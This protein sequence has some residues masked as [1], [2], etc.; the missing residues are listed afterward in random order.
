MKSNVPYHIVHLSDLHLTPSDGKARSEPNILGPLKG[1]NE[2]FRQLLTQKSITNANLI[3]VTGDITDRGDVQSWK[4]FWNVIRD[5]G[6]WKKTL[7]VPGNHD[8]C[9]LGVRTG[10]KK[11]LAKRDLKR[12]V[13]GLQ[14]GKQHIK[15]PWAKQVD[16]RIV[17]F[18]VDSNNAG[19]YGV[20]D[21][22]F[23]RIGYY[24]FLALGDL[25]RKYSTVPVKIVC[26]HHSPNLC[27]A[28]TA[29]KRNMKAYSAMDRL[30][31]QMNQKDRQFLRVLCNSHRVRLILHGHLHKADMRHVSGVRIVGAPAS[32]QPLNKRKRTFQFYEY[33]V[34]GDGGR[35]NRYL[36][37]VTL[38]RP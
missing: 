25:F 1:M 13:N 23:G 9:C 20:L 8:L 15:F 19:N 7:V 35:V 17:I 26:L 29:A 36:R 14:M 38:S 21:N 10:S 34:R 24:Q 6:I 33:V 5:A 2:N 4:V 12:V 37:T 32:T 31:T 11:D 3:L 18:G 22:A 30:M 27:R 16:K 28:E